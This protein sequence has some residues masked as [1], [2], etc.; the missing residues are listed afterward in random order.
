MKTL[1]LMRH[2][3]SGWDDPNLSDRER[4]L[5]T[6]GQRDAPRVGAW[7]KAKGYVADVAFVSDAHRTQETWT[8]LDLPVPA[9]FHADLYLAEPNEMMAHVMN[10]EADTVMVLGHN[11]GMGEL[12]AGLAADWPSNPRFMQFPTASVCV[13][14]FEIATWSDI[15]EASGTVVAFQTPHDL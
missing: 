9:S 15:A 14:T 13:L 1:I 4:S 3:K 8:L 11:P 7:L 6:R 5:N 12:S 2:A 10:A